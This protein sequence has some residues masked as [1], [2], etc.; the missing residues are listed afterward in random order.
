MILQVCVKLPSISQHSL[1]FPA[2]QSRVNRVLKVI[3]SIFCCLRRFSGFAF[4]SCVL[5]V[6]LP[7]FPAVAVTVLVGDRSRAP[8]VPAIRALL[9]CGIVH[10]GPALTAWRFM[11]FWWIWVA[12]G[13]PE[14]LIYSIVLV[15]LPSTVLVAVSLSWSFRIII[16]FAWKESGDISPSLTSHSL[17]LQNKKRHSIHLDRTNTSAKS[18][19]KS[20]NTFPH[21]FQ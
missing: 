20:H 8:H 9:L 17:N 19:S 4:P 2:V 15:A 1:P 14:A 10:I 16:W 18:N 11:S 3:P 5:P 12:K 6:G 7:V 21:L 13:L